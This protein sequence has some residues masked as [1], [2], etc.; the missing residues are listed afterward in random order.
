[1]EQVLALNDLL[2]LI[3]RNMPIWN[4]TA[5]DHMK[6]A[7][8]R[9]TYIKAR[10]DQLVKRLQ[11][12]T[13]NPTD[14]FISYI[15]FGKDIAGNQVGTLGIG[16]LF[17][18]VAEVLLNPRFFFDLTSECRYFQNV[19]KFVTTAY[20]D[21]PEITLRYKSALTSLE[22]VQSQ[23]EQ[24]KCHVTFRNLASERGWLHVFVS[25]ASTLSLQFPDILDHIH[26][27]ESFI[28]Q[29]HKYSKYTTMVREAQSIIMTAYQEFAMRLSQDQIERIEMDIKALEKKDFLAM[30]R[31]TADMMMKKPDVWMHE[32]VELLKSYGLLDC[33]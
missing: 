10:T 21:E 26:N 9:L 33:K 25:R 6:L 4:E 22:D 15:R 30:I 7:N 24:S 28:D 1:M 8:R 29:Y 18:A 11:K 2:N 17:N 23:I 12:T 3:S 20:S 31:Q 27:I 14:L 19:E 5:N 32:R 16:N 13:K